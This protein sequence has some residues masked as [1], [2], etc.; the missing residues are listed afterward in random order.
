MKASDKFRASS[1]ALMDDENV[2]SQALVRAAELIRGDCVIQSPRHSNKKTNT[3]Y[4]TEMCRNWDE[5]G[6]C[7]YGRSCQFA[8]GSSELRTVKRHG[9]W[10]T[11]T[12]LA[13]VNGG[14]TYGS[15][16]CYARKFPL[17]LQL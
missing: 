17:I 12:C 16:C 6:E 9:Q 10:K 11:K 15:R 7:R 5:S 8:H 14:C 4:K 2:A 3:L 13:W 1:E